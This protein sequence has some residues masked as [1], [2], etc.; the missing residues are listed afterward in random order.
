M[1]SIIVMAVFGGLCGLGFLAV[2][3]LIAKNGK[4]QF[5]R[6]EFASAQDVHALAQ[7]WAGRNGYALKRSEGELRVYQKGTGFLTAPMF[8]EVD[9]AGGRWSLKSYVRINGLI[10]Q[11][12]VGL[13]GDGFLVKLPRSL[14]KKAQNELY[15]SLDLAPLK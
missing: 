2:M 10:V 6:T 4:H 11:G 3:A 1:V 9:R 5:D 8:L 12:D 15:A 14:A 13:S 7:A